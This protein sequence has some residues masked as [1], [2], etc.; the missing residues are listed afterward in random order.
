MRVCFISDS[1]VRE[2]EI[3]DGLNKATDFLLVYTNYSSP[4]FGIDKVKLF[5]Q[6]HDIPLIVHDFA[7]RRARSLKGLFE[8]LRLI[9]KIK[10]FNPDIILWFTAVK[11]SSRLFKTLDW[12]RRLK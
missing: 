1:L 6:N 7:H 12:I 8:D 10:K 5:C 11:Y 2:Q 9:K 3:V 4:N